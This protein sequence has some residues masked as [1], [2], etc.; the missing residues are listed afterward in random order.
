MVSWYPRSARKSHILLITSHLMTGSGGKVATNMTQT[1]Y[2]EI[3]MLLDLDS[4]T[5][6]VYQHGKLL[7]TLMDGLAGN[8]AGLRVDNI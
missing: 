8:T 6:S 3:G 5:L 2:K 4:S 1:D 7:G